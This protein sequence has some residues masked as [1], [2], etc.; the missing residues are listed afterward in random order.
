M[1][2][3]HT[4]TIIDPPIPIG[5]ILPIERLFLAGVFTEDVKDRTACYHSAHGANDRISLD[6]EQ[7][8]SSLDDATAGTSRLAKYLLEEYTDAI[9]HDREIEIDL[10]GDLWPDVLQDIVRRSAELDHLIVTVAYTCTKMRTD[11]FG[12]S[13]MLIT[14][15]SIRWESTSTLLDRFYAEASANGEIDHGD[16]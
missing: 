7:V 13:A 6:G 1:A 5:A 4:P 9:T 14:A 10:C 8:R 15:G 16:S 12:G 3:Y 11:G 2:G